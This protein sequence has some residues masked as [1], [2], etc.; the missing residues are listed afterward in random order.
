MAKQTSTIKIPPQNIE[1]EMSVLGSL[2]I[3]KNAI[4]KV[5]DNLEPRDFYKD[6][7]GKIYEAALDLFKN[8]QPIDILS[9]TARLKEKKELEA[10]G[11]TGYLAEVVNFVPTAS[12]VGHYADIVRK[13]RTLRD[14]IDASHHISSL[15]Y[16]EEKNME[17]V[18]DEAE[19]KVF[20][21]AQRS[22]KHDFLK[23][24]EALESAWERIDDIHKNKG[25]LR[26]VPTGFPD[27]DNILG[28]LQ[29]SDLIVLAARP[30]L[31]KTALALDIARNVA[32]EEKKPVAIFSLEMS[33]EQLLD[34][35]LAAE[36][37]VDSWKLRTGNLSD[38]GE[39]NDFIRIRNAMELLADAPMFIDDSAMPTLM[40][41]RAMARRLHAQ[42]ELGLIVI[43]YLQLIKTNE[44]IESRVQEVSEISR[45]LKALAKELNV[46]VLAVSQLSRAI[47]MRT[48]GIPRLADLRESGSIEQDADVVMFIYREDKAKRNSDRPGIAEIMVEKHR[49][50]KTGKIELYFKE[51]EISF[52]SL[53]KHF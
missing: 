52:K 8:R 17:N 47:E 24:G 44:K 42:H 46:P 1:A 49:N 14:L 12:H 27:L 11:G 15:G 19:Q 48:D 25:K 53:A 51:D 45:S 32:V 30:S 4:D 16:D 34:R 41:I 43:D 38:K 10:V 28:G 39:E 22:L 9:V 26:G 6:A 33:K 31:G 13:K 36:A 23:I 21:I 35:I 5:C 2:M 20:S 3:D 29:K 18:L 40:Q 7:H 50:G 37:R